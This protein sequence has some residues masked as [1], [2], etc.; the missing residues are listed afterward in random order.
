MNID[1]PPRNEKKVIHSPVNQCI[2]CYSKENKLTDEH[3]IPFSLG[4]LLILPKASCKA[5]AKITAK[6]EG[7]FSRA[8]FGNLRMRY[9]LPTRRKKE[10]LKYIEVERIGKFN[11][12]Q[13]IKIPV[14]EFP[15]PTFIY[16]CTKAGILEGK[17]F[18]VDNYP[19]WQPSILCDTNQMDVFQKKYGENITFKF[20]I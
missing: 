12:R 20:N 2:Y 10:R 3:I 7:V 1:F 9:N 8:I 15:A 16:K 14:S 13:K 4:G 5:C 6:F 19:N 17:P 18:T 11:I